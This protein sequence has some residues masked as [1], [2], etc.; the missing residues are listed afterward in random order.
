LPKNI[1]RKKKKWKLISFLDVG[2]ET[3]KAFPSA[4]G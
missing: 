3:M 1:P 4:M 2:A